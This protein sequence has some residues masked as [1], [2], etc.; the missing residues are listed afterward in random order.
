MQL[1]ELKGKM[2]KIETVIPELQEHINELHKDVVDVVAK[3]GEIQYV[4]DHYLQVN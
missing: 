4:V 2:A 3:H 1:S